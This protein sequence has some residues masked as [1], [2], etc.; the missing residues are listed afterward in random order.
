MLRLVAGRLTQPVNS[1]LAAYLPPTA[2]LV[3]GGFVL[4]L[5]LAIP[6]GM[7]SASRAGSLLDRGIFG[8]TV[9]G[10]VLHPFL[11]GLALRAGAGRLDL[12][13]AGA[14]ARCEARYR[15]SGRRARPDSVAVSPTG[16]TTW[17]SRG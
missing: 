16:A 8:F 2:S 5:L 3:L 4:T 12:A 6:L 14:T 15:S 10:V 7:L 17:R 11:V 1:I 9:I 13:P